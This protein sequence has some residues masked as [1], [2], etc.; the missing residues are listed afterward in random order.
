MMCVGSGFA[1]SE[2]S[3]PNHLDLGSQ[4]HEVAI[5]ICAHNHRSRTSTSA[6]MCRCTS[7]PAT[8]ECACSCATC[9]SVCECTLSCLLVPF[10]RFLHVHV[11]RQDFAANPGCHIERIYSIIHTSVVAILSGSV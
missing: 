9:A 4:V 8:N 3:Y 2:W 11:F 6:L 7:T 5:H 1:E 10:S